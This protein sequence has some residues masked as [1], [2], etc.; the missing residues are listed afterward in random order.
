MSR[1]CEVTPC[2]AEPEFGRA[3]CAVHRHYARAGA[4][5]ISKDSQGRGGK[6]CIVCN[7]T[8]ADTDWVFK[9]MVERWTV[10]R[11]GDRFG[12]QHAT[13]VR[14]QVAPPAPVVVSLFE[15]GA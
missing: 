6:K 7:K 14:G 13:C 8:F 4:L 2:P 9:N 5:R 1:I 15:E 12:H 3:T 11:A 10:K